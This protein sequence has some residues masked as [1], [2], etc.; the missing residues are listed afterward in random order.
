VES[1]IGM[2]LI[3]GLPVDRKDC[4][5]LARILWG[6]GTHIGIA[7]PQSSKGD[8]IGHVKDFGG[9]SGLPTTRGYESR[10]ALPFH[11]DRCDITMLMCV[12][13]ACSGGDSSVVSGLA[14]HNLMLARR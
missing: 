12:R 1:G 11:T 8:V 2:A 14:V 4:D 9:D 5:F 6:L 10:I 7:L 3:R 13:P